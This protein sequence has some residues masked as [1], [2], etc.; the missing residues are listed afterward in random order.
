MELEISSKWSRIIVIVVGIA[1]FSPVILFAN[2]AQSSS[3]LASSEA[4]VQ[5][6][7]VIVQVR[8]G[9]PARLRIPK[10][11]VDASI[12]FVGLTPLGAMGA[13]EGPATAAWFD[14][15]PRPGEN[16]T[17]IIDG[18]Y[19][20][21]DT[22]PTIFNSLSTLKVGDKIYVED[23]KGITNTFVVRNIK[24]YSKDEIASDL[25]SSNDGKAHLNLITCEGVWSAAQKSYSNRLV[26][27]ADKE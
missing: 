20:W 11:A 22:I 5:S 7:P 9:L 25:F 1:F 2:G 14:L 18:H 13:P 10:I 23:E 27:F 16:G 26:V 12:D 4:V 15:G 8:S 3:S 21:K 17:A 24:S 19:G 6:I